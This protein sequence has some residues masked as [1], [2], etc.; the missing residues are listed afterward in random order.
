MLLSSLEHLILESNQI[1]QFPH[2]IDRLKKLTILRLRQNHPRKNER[3]DVNISGPSE[4]SALLKEIVA[5][6]ALSRAVYEVLAIHRFGGSEDANSF[7]QIP[8]DVIRFVLVPWICKIWR[9]EKKN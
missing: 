9:N 1:R 3:W 5:P 8:K 4:C 2:S 7:H 6:Y